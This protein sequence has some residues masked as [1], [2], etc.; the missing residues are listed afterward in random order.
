[1]ED[2]SNEPILVK[3]SKPDSSFVR[4]LSKFQQRILYSSIMNDFQVGFPT[5][6]LLPF[7]PFVDRF[8]FCLFRFVLFC[9]VLCCFMFLFEKKKNHREK[10]TWSET[11]SEEQIISFDFD[12]HI[13]SLDFSK[14]GKINKQIYKQT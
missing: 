10:W 14:E 7:N 4:G 1:L 8:V 2:D 3:M 9:F 11:K 5:A 13:Q 12:S 6:M